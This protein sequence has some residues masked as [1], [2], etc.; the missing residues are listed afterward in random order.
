M[1]KQIATRKYRKVKIFKMTTNKNCPKSQ[2]KAK[3]SNLI[4]VP[5]GQNSK[6]LI[7]VPGT[8]I[9]KTRVAKK[10]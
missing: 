3:S 10:T 1:C 4:N 9:W 8:F 5:P 7:N 2:T 6:K